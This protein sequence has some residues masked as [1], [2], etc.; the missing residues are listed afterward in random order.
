MRIR[1]MPRR[2]IQNP[3]TNPIVRRTENKHLLLW[4][5]LD[6]TIG[7]FVSGVAPQD[8]AGDLV[9]DGGGEGGDDVVHYCCALAVWKGLHV[10]CV[11]AS[12]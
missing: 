12:V 1:Q 9:L 6:H 11:S 2:N 7:L 3:P 4:E 8:T 5:A 10:S